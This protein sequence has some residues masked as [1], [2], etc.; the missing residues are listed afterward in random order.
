MTMKT[1]ILAGL[2]AATGLQPVGA[3]QPPALREI[4]YK[5]TATGDLQLSLHLPAVA[6]PGQRP[7]VVWVHG[8]GWSRGSKDDLPGS[9]PH[10]YRALLQQGYA[11]ASVGYRLSGEAR[12]PAP[13]QDINDALNFLHDRGSEYGVDGSAVVMAGRSAGGHL[14]SLVGLIN[15]H[16][17]PSFMKPAL[18][19]VKGIVS[20]FGP[21]DLLISEG[22][23]S[24]SQERLARSPTARMLGNVPAD[25]P[26]LA[27][28][29][30]P[31][32][33][34]SR[35][36]APTLLLHGRQD[37]QVPLAHSIA[38]QQAL[39]AQDVETALR[40]EDDAAHSAKVFDSAS[41]VPAVVMFVQRHL[42]GPSQPQPH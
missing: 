20:F 40:I 41:H 15:G 27:R 24:M 12:F 31:I 36:S 22:T 28:Q 5:T 23:R 18:Y 21:S 37:V 6:V 19:K 25:N 13:V 35:Q 9:N 16:S 26:A 3:A 42:P 33:Y 14:A 32:N 29:A 30:S 8:G 11:I 2:L 4:T 10:L 1:I 39:K 7:L 17:T 38:L 34:V